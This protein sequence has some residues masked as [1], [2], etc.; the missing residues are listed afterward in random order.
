MNSVPVDPINN[1][2]I[3]APTTGMY[4]YRYFCYEYTING[5]WA[6]GSGPHLGY[7]REAP[8]ARTSIHYK[9]GDE[10]VNPAAYS[11]NRADATYKC[12]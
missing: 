7:Y 3:H 10:Q 8:V 5:T 12:R 2:T 4:A 1:T 11:A 6:T 9:N